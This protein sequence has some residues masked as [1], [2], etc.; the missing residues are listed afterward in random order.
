MSILPMKYKQILKTSYN[1]LK[2]FVASY[3]RKGDHI[4]I[5]KY[6]HVFEKGY[7]SRTATIRYPLLS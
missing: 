4:R 1:H 2:I 7:I 3:F 5:S 6:K